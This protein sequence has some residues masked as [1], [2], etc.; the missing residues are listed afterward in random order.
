MAK[1]PAF[2]FYTGDWMKDPCVRALCAEGRGLWIDM[3][4]LMWDSPKKGCLCAP[5]GNAFSNAHV[6]RMTGIP[7]GRVVTLINE[8]EEIGVFSRGDDGVIFCRRMVRDEENRTK[9]RERVKKHRISNANVTLD[10][11]GGVTQVK[12]PSSSSS[13]SS[14][15]VNKPLTPSRGTR[16]K[17]RMTPDE[18]LSELDLSAFSGDFIEELKKWVPYRIA[19]KNIVGAKVEFFQNQ[20]ESLKEMGEANAVATMKHSRIQQFQGLVTPN[21]TPSA[22]PNGASGSSEGSKQVYQIKARKEA[23][24]AEIKAID[25]RTSVAAM[26]PMYSPE[27]RKARRELGAKLGELNREL[28]EI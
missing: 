10:V 13:S 19:K 11:T 5:N 25:N 3:L 14:T 24:E 28:L 16:G 12:Q 23:V 17:K 21:G 2:Q 6:T 4:C 22:S 1:A 27:D 18:V 8:M 7:E 26:G 20:V 15:S 9:T